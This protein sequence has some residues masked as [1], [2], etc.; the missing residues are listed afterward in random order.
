MM[1]RALTISDGA[2]LDLITYDAAEDN[3]GRNSPGI[4]TVL[5][6]ACPEASLQICCNPYQ[7]SDQEASLTH[8]YDNEKNY[9]QNLK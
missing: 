7:K 6:E 2:F 3:N 4:Y 9:N 1:W 5:Y 8:I